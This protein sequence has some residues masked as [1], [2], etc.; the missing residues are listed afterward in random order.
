MMKAII[1]RFFPISKGV[2]MLFLL[3]YTQIFAA[4]PLSQLKQFGSVAA[5]A[6]ACLD[7]KKIPTKLN[8]VLSDANLDRQILESLIEA[9]NYGYKN[10]LLSHKMWFYGKETWNKFPF[11]CNNEKDIAFIKR[12]ESAILKGIKT[13]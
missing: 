3:T 6:E 2:I 13:E 10:A 11:D 7:S 1:K 12:A 8:K 5:L 4:S 9:Y